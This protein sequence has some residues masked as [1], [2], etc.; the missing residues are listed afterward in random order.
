MTINV[1]EQTIEEI[2]ERLKK[3]STDFNK[4]DYLESAVKTGSYSFEIKRFLYGELASI[5]EERKLY[6]KAVKAMANKAASGVMKKEKI[7]DFM[8]AAE[9]YA[10]LGRIEEAE[11]M[12]LGASREATIPEKAGVT[13][14]RKNIYL[15]TAKNLE[16]KGKK[17]SAV[18]FYEKL[19]KMKLDESEKEEIKRTLLDRYKALGRFREARMLEGD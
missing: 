8:A 1:R 16:A 6:E 19:L 11:N 4:L 3:M 14:A 17:A 7:E 13:L 18:A 12:F 2:Q 9:L 10:K 15:V 5:Y